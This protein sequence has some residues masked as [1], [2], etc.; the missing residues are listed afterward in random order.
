[1]LVAAANRDEAKF[2]NGERFDINR[3]RQAHLTFGYGFHSC[4]GNALARVE[5]RIALDEILNRFADWD[6]DLDNAKL[7][8]TSTVRGWETLPAFT[9]KARGKA[10]R[11]RQAAEPA[12]APLP[13]GAESWTLTLQTPMGPQ[14]MTLHMAR[15][16]A[17]FTGR[18]DSP[19]G[20]E[21]VKNGAIAGGRFTWTMDAKKPMP[22]T[23]KFDVRI[24]GHAMAGHAELGTFGKA[25]LSGKRTGA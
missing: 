5:G 13:E 24:E 16:G 2:A 19:M 11:R 25:E 3:E 20:S 9:P 4:L 1:M 17:G 23:L 18:I 10:P 6:V 8:S 12:L 7:S 14:E 21:P 15:E 22:I